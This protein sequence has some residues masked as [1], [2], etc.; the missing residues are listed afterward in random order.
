M[1]SIGAVSISG[2][3]AAAAQFQ[4]SA[5]RIANA[6]DG[7]DMAAELANIVTSETSFAANT[8]ALKA[9][10]DMVGQLLDIMA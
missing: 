9:Q 3:M 8:K 2:M 4:A 7:G 5:M 10:T 1:S 6:S